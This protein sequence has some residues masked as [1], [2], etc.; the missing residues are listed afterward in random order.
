LTFENVEQDEMGYWF[1]FVRSKQRSI[2][3][4]STICVPRRQ[5]DW[6]SV[7]NDVTR[8]PIDFDPASVLDIYFN[9]LMIDLQC[10]KEDLKGCIFKGTH[11]V[12][13]KKFTSVNV[14][15]NTLGGVGVE[16]ASEL[17][18]P[19]PETFTGHCWR[20]SAGTNASNAGVNVTT[21]MA[22]MGWACP[23]TAMEYVKHSRLTSLKM[24]MY[25]A[26]VQ[27]QNVTDPFPNVP[28]RSRKTVF[29]NF[30]LKNS[31]EKECESEEQK[32][33]ECESEKEKECESEKEKQ[34]EKEC[35]S[36]SV[37]M[38]HVDGGACVHGVGEVDV[39]EKSVESVPSG[40][41]SSVGSVFNLSNVDP[42]LGSFFP[43]LSN[44]GNVNVHFHFGD[45]K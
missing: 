23:K 28:F 35:E 13:G 37:V 40:A 6:T 36:V 15:K 33:K 45:S 9:R 17:C 16:V 29:R 34:K 2:S 7:S 22:M 8:R 11:G 25:L 41:L 27:R 5:S 4:C 26:N 21:L 19:Y 31:I 24:S 1:S 44:H 18:L 12:N 10:Q 39:V 32:E 3:E 14:G 42:R 30:D 20:R 38:E 43:N